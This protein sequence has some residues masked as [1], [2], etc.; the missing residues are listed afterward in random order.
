MNVGSHGVIIKLPC[1]TRAPHGNMLF[2]I[3]LSL[4]FGF[5]I[6]SVRRSRRDVLHKP[7]ASAAGHEPVQPDSHLQVAPRA[8]AD[9]VVTIESLDR[10]TPGAREVAV[11]PDL[12]GTDRPMGHGWRGPYLLSE[13]ASVAQN[14]IGFMMQYVDGHKQGIAA[15]AF[16]RL[17]DAHQAER[18]DSR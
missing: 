2:L 11:R 10:D 8:A 4:G 5:L 1:G 16:L 18:L 3:L 15:Q 9:G 12:P 17:K 6:G 14:L 7:V 13:W